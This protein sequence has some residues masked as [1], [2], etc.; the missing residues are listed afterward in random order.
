MGLGRELTHQKD[1]GER[2][3]YAPVA[4]D[5]GKTVRIRVT[6]KSSAGTTVCTLLSTQLIQTETLTSAKPTVTGQLSVGSTLTAST[7]TIFTY[8]GLCNNAA[9]FGAAS[10]TYRVADAGKNLSVKVTGTNPGYTTAA[11]TSSQTAAVPTPA[12]EPVIVP[13]TPT[14][15]ATSV[16]AHHCPRR[17]ASGHPA[18]SPS[19]TSGCAA[20]PRPPGPHT[21]GSH[22]LH[23]HGR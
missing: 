2:T 23:L 14:I 17:S 8:Q 11:Q 19:P 5:L 22:R 1:P 4:A 18:R 13:P 3:T 9:I 20:A 21:P 16:V 6:G 12:P 10:S 7:G 15:T